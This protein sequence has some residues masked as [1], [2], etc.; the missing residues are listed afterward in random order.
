MAG[1]S[2]LRLFF[3]PFEMDASTGE[4]FKHGSRIRLSGQPLRIL[5]ILS[6]NPGALITRDQLREQIWGAGTFV[7]FEHGLNAAMNKLR[8]ALGDSA[9][10]PKYIE[11]VAGQ[12][13]RFI[14]KIEPQAAA[15]TAV[16]SISSP[17]SR[18]RTAFAAAAVAAAMLISFGLGW[19]FHRAAPV[20]PFNR[21]VLMLTT[22]SALTST[23]AISRDAKLVAYSS[24]INNNG[25]LDLYVKQVAGGEP[26]RLTS[27]GGGNTQPDFSPDGSKIVFRSD[28]E[29]GGIYVIP[30]LGG[31][32]RFL[33]PKG[34]NPK[35]S[36]D[37]SR[38]TYW[39]GTTLIAPNVPGNGSLWVAPLS[40]GEL[41]RIAAN[42]VSARFPIWLP[43]G[44]DILFVGSN[45]TSTA[46]NENADWWVADADGGRARPTGAF[47]S[48]FRSVPDFFPSP[49]LGVRGAPQP[50]CWRDANTLVFAAQYGSKG[51]WT[52]RFSPDGNLA[53]GLTRLTT[54]GGDEVDPSCAWDGSVAFTK[55]STQTNIWSLPLDL[56][57]PR[58]GGRLQQ[59]TQGTALRDYVS[60]SRD[61]R[62]VAFASDQHGPLNI[63]LRD[64]VT[65]HE[66]QLRESP[67]TERYPATAPSGSRVA[68]SV[69][70]GQKRSL[71]IGAPGAPAEKLCDDCLRATDWS[72]DE[73]S[74]LIFA[75]A[76]YRIEL[77]DIASHRRTVLFGHPAHN[78]FMGRFSPDHHWV[79]FTE[80]LG[81]DRARIVIAP[82]VG[83]PSARESAWIPIADATPTDF[84]NWSPDGKTLYFTSRRD[85]FECFWAQRLDERRHPVGDPVG[86]LHLH[87]RQAYNS[88][89]WAANGGR[90]AMVLLERTGNIG[91]IPGGDK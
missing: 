70:E 75:G 24:D 38:V 67:F 91:L 63:W 58:S 39:I 61:G 45:A 7:D 90:L 5:L 26:I 50:G 33:A 36:P 32:A 30:A 29:G 1:V 2:Q 81:G 43:D 42:V 69:Y 78:L 9:E 88:L 3:G 82:A 53:G 8:R 72:A 68:W 56:D 28:R 15:D 83:A 85:G 48:L 86:V 62:F 16:V 34:R 27:D 54:G 46:A 73:K 40:A 57:H 65:G 10:T 20:R 52:A 77:L 4:L 80:R 23:P 44:K 59:V 64:T 76:P 19:W 74:L 18:R 51:L 87:G 60:L 84:A 47:D 79:S 13:Y 55:G 35:F 31:E 22:D 14:G 25:H 11:T 6:S 71:Y 41:R 37:G 21:K 17:R 66:T 49:S 12:G 89:G